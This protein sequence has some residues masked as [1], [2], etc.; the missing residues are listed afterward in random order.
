MK[1]VSSEQGKGVW[2]LIF[3]QFPQS[4]ETAISI[5][6]ITAMLLAGGAWCC[7]CFMKGLSLFLPRFNQGRATIPSYLRNVIW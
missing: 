1:R 4:L 5:A 6:T 2:R 3:R 7:N